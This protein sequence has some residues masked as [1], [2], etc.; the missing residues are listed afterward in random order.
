MVALRLARYVEGRFD[1]ALKSVLPG[2]GITAFRASP[3]T[4]ADG[5]LRLGVGSQLASL[6]NAPTT[7]RDVLVERL[8]SGRGSAIKGQARGRSLED[9]VEAVVTEVFGAD[10][11]DTRC[12]FVGAKGT[13]TE[14]ADVAILRRKIHRS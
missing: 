13:S 8:K 3:N 9:W 2:R 12:R 10:R 11:F 5:L 6:T 14:K 1:N 7:W 4:F